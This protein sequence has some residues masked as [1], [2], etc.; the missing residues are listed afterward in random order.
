MDRVKKYMIVNEGTNVAKDVARKHTSGM[1]DLRLVVSELNDFLNSEPE[2][3]KAMIK[4]L[5]KAEK[6]LD[7]VDG[8]L[9][10]LIIEL[11]HATV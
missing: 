2:M 8:T 1:V 3:S 11:R 6:A 7:M 4:D 5:K 9:A 10:K